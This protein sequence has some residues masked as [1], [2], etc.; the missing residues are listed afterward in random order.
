VPQV[1]DLKNITINKF[2]SETKA[3][4]SQLKN[5]IQTVQSDI[6]SPNFDRAQKKAKQDQISQ[7]EASLLTWEGILLL[8][9]LGMMEDNRAID[10]DRSAATLDAAVQAAGGR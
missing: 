1:L 2:V 3:L 5:K 8:S 7:L 6:N 10:T 9:E 4:M